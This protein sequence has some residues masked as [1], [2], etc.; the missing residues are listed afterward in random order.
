MIRK[1]LFGRPVLRIESNRDRE[2]H[3]TWLELFY[4]LVFVAAI[5]QLASN[6]SK[7]YSIIGLLQFAALFFPVWMAW[8]GHTVY[9][10]RFD[11]DDLG[12]TLL[13]MAQMIAVAALAI[14][15]PGALSTTSAGFALSYA[16]V[17]FILI[18]QYYRAGRQIPKVRPMTNRYLM[19]F[20]PAALLWLI[21]VFVP[22][23]WRFYLWGLA[24]FLEFLT[25]GLVGKY[26]LE[27]PPDPTHF[28]ERFGLFTIIVLGETVVAI[29]INIGEQGLNATSA[30][31]GI[32]GL[33]IAFSIWW[34]YFR[35]VWVEASQERMGK[36]LEELFRVDRTEAVDSKRQSIKLFLGGLKF[37]LFIMSIVVIAVGI[38]HVIH[39]SPGASLPPVETWI[40]CGSLAFCWL[41]LNAIASSLPGVKST[42]EIRRFMMPHHIITMLMIGAGAFGHVISGIAIVG[43]LTLLS[44][45]QVLLSLREPPELAFQ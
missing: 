2:R 30:V 14:S 27:F 15:I 28:P 8:A 39:L 11:S 9:L 44:V 5:A 4:D 40:L 19:G 22:N 21:S 25:P 37:F 26:Q 18:A 6:L 35:G 38:E 1:D 43:L 32:M 12:H 41:G 13:T 3:A 42:P 29:I 10:T 20:T 17:R 45:T 36:V 7:D 34:G 24:M 31:V 33:V 16:V 23:P